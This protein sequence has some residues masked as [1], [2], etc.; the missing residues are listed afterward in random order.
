MARLNNGINVINVKVVEKPRDSVMF[1]NQ[2][3]T[4]Y[5]NLKEQFKLNLP[6]CGAENGLYFTRAGKSSD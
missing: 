6:N 5:I 4:T 2:W 1:Q 3:D